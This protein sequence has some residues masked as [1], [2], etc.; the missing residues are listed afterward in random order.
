MNH[1]PFTDGT[2]AYDD[3]GD[4]PPDVFAGTGH[5]VNMEQPQRFSNTVRRFPDGPSGPG[6][7]R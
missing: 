4:G 6:L 5:M 1:A 3:I 7:M 2:L